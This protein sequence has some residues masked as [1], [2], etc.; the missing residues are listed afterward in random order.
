[1]S[2]TRGREHD[3]EETDLNVNSESMVRFSSGKATGF[4][5][6]IGQSDAMR[7]VFGRLEHAA[8]T[9][10]T[11]LLEGPLGVGKEEA[12][13]AVHRQSA[14]APGPFIGVECPAIASEE[15]ERELFG[16]ESRGR[17]GAFENATGG[18][19]FLEEVGALSLAAQLQVLRVIEQRMLRR[20]GGLDPIEVDVR[21]I[22]S[23]TTDLRHAV[24]EGTFRS[25][26]YFRLSMTKISLPALAERSEDILPITLAILKQAGASEAHTQRFTSDA[27]IEH[28]K[29]AE[30]PDNVRGLRT[31]LERCL[32]MENEGPL[33]ELEL[34]PVAGIATSFVVDASLTYAEARKLAIAEFERQYLRLLLERTRGN[35]SRAAREAGIDRVY[36]HRLMRRHQIRR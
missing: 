21:V 6:L 26:L 25:E 4:G 28:L 22:A 27:F 3:E 14:R 34:T 36:M 29:R 33:S 9:D 10:G 11:L 5:S 18:S 17:T 13:A 23:S 1:M 8:Q 20:L 12:A 2:S 7:A 16:D 31:Y 35:V 32:V 30:W 24:Q 19:I 15:M